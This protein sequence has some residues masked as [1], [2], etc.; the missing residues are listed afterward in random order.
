MRLFLVTL[1]LL[2]AGCAESRSEGCH[3][4]AYGLNPG[5]WQPNAADLRPCAVRRV[6]R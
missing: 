2:A 5:H 3:A 6:G 4:P 1:L